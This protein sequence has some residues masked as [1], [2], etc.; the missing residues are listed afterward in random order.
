MFPVASAFKAPACCC[1]P[2]LGLLVCVAIFAP[3]APALAEG[4]TDAGDRDGESHALV[5]ELILGESPYPQEAGELQVTLSVE[6]LSTEEENTTDLV[7]ELELGITD[8]LQV[9]VEV[10]Y[11]WIDGKE[12]EEDEDGL[13]DVGVSVLCVLL[14]DDALILSGAVEVNFPSGDEDKELGEGKIEVEPMLLGAARFDGIELYGGV[15]GEITD[16]DE[17]FTYSAGLVAALGPVVGLLEVSGESGA[18]GGGDEAVIA[19]GLA[20]EV[21][22]DVELLIGVPIGLNDDSP[23][24]GATFRVTAEF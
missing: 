15:G 14:N 20:V 6:H 12:G 7:A 17:V 4:D 1:R 22:D 5:E 2:C 24:W 16:E 18:E 8:W 23:D 13:R 9:G 10:P 11:R 3:A 19:P 21:M